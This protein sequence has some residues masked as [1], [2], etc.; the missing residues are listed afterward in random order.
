MRWCRVAT[1]NEHLYRLAWQGYV[2]NYVTN[3]FRQN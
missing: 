3:F 2:T 1:S